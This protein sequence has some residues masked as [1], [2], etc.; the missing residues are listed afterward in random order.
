MNKITAALLLAPALG[1]GLLAWAFKSKA[2]EIQVDGCATT[3]LAGRV[4]LATL[5]RLVGLAPTWQV[6]R[7]GLPKPALRAVEKR[8][9]PTACGPAEV[10]FYWP[11]CEAAG[12]LPVFV[13]FHGGGFVLG[14]YEQDGPLCRYWAHYACCVVINVDYA[15][16]PEYPFP[17]PVLQCYELVK[18][19]HNQAASLGYDASR[20][21]VGGQSAGGNLAAAVAL[22]QRERREFPLALQVLD[23]SVLNQAKP[24]SQKHVLPHQ[25]QVLSVELAD[26]FTR[27]YT[28]CPAEQHNPLASP[29]LAPDLA[30]LAPALVIAAGN[31]LLRDDS[32]EYVARL[33]QA[34]I[35]VDYHEF[36]GVDHIFTHAGPAAAALAA[37]NL[38]GQA[39]QQAFQP[40]PRGVS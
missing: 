4:R 14:G 23:Y 22:L 16:A 30:G 32:R 13:N 34:G 25:E 19:V 18:W 7:L 11:A 15:L 24:S 36:A 2:Y 17:A 39:L 27:L 5:R 29:V 40:G 38:I 35:A 31:D 9:V 3:T 21:A 12:P 6:R 37:W 28:P 33:R 1:A 26:F 8:V 10:T 20:L